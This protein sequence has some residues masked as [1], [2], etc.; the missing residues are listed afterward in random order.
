MRHRADLLLVGLL[1]ACSADTTVP[2][3]DAEAASSRTMRGLYSYMAD[4]GM[5]V[6]WSPGATESP[7]MSLTH[8][9]WSLA[10][11]R[12]APPPPDDRGRIRLEFTADRM[13]AN[14]GCNTGSAGYR[15]EGGALALGPM[16]TT[17]MACVGAAA[18]YEPAFFA[19]LAARPLL[20]TESGDLALAKD[21]THLRFRS[22]PMASA[23]AVQRFIYVASERKPCTGV[24]TMQ[25][26]R[27][28][29]A[30]SSTWSWS[31]G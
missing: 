17:R 12:L 15:I 13:S 5:F 30:G 22:V 20:T 26:M 18:Q 10:D 8:T 25:C 16:T 24:A 11:S 7:M 21:G 31:S 4:A 27:P 29:S 3:T 28:R 2:V 23:D 19:F 6:E 9:R 1:V 14:S